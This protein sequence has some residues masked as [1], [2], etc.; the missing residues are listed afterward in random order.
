MLGKIMGGGLNGTSEYKECFE[1][2]RCTVYTETVVGLGGFPLLLSLLLLLYSDASHDFR[3]APTLV[4]YELPQYELRAVFALFAI[5]LSSPQ[6]HQRPTPPVTHRLIGKGQQ[7]NWRVK[8][9]RW[10][11]W[12]TCIWIHC[13]NT[14]SNNY[15]KRSRLRQPV[16]EA[17]SCKNILKRS[18][19][20]GK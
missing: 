9:I 14:I 12:N 2:G 10:H 13:S 16:R 1:G 18:L 11:L 17:Q 5:S 19:L 20:L 3:T 6:Y 7:S 8:S 15:S 4:L